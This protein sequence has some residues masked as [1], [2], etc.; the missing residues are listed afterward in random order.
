[1]TI[2]EKATVG[3][4]DDFRSEFGRDLQFW[5]FFTMLKD[6][7]R[8]SKF[9]SLTDYSERQFEDIRVRVSELLFHEMAHAVD[10]MPVNLVTTADP[11]MTPLEATKAV[12]DQQVANGL[13]NT[14][15][16]YSNTLFE[17]AQVRYHGEEASEFQKTLTAYDVGAEMAIDGAS[18]FYAYSTI[19]EDVATLFAA[20]MMKKHFDVDFTIAFVQKPA[21]EDNYSCDEL[22]VGWGA[23]NRVADP[24]VSPRARWVVDTIYGSDA[25]NSQFFNTGQGDVSTMTPGVDWCSNLEPSTLATRDR[26]ANLKSTDQ[27]YAREAERMQLLED[28]RPRHY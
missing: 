7:E 1:L 24:L 18:E 5:S 16:L 21:D 14:L 3:I 19:R 6:G 27:S 10:S 11:T 2:E 9:F 22:L 25:E 12:S 8:A 26:N 23:R 13:Y 20:A 28:H 17:V 15:P 4:Q